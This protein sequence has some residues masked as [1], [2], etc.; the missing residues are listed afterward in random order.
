M[1][2]LFWF[3]IG[4][5]P[6]EEAVRAYVAETYLAAFFALQLC[7]ARIFEPEQ[8]DGAFELMRTYPV[9]P[10]AWFLSKLSTVWLTGAI[11]LL[12]SML[13]GAF[14]HGQIDRPLLDGTLIV[15]GFSTLLGLGAIGIMLASI[16]MR[17]SARQIMFPLIYFPL[18]VPLL[19]AATQSSEMHIINNASLS[20]LSESWLGLLAAFDLIYVAIGLL[21]YDQLLFEEAP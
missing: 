7:F 4:E 16:T 19:L 5:L 2:L 1:L 13:L 15:I 10:T 6:N 20:T 14:F 17:S 3:A 18:T 8:R 11:V 21:L 12:A 9:S